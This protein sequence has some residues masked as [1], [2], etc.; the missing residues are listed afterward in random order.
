MGDICFAAHMVALELTPVQ[1]LEKKVKN[2]GINASLRYEPGAMA[3]H[4][5][6]CLDCSSS[7]R[8]QN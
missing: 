5:E 1:F 4:G 2:L 6:D 3:G 8:L 7:A